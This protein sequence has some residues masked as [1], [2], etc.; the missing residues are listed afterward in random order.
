MSSIGML[1][2]VET[3]S[4]EVPEPKLDLT[5]SLLVEHCGCLLFD[6]NRHGNRKNDK[7]MGMTMAKK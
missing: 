5:E 7:Q 6:C 1:V 2:V 4:R 3:L